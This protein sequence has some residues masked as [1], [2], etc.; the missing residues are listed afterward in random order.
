MFEVND[1]YKRLFEVLQETELGNQLVTGLNNLENENNQ[2][3]ADKEISDG[4][5]SVL[6]SELEITKT[7]L[8]ELILGGGL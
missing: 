8:D 1:K 4:K 6:E 7:A 2:L 5:I 3:K